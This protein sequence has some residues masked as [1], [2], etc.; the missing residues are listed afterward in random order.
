MKNP[1]SRFALSLIVVVLQSA[2]FVW[3]QS[4]QSET[5]PPAAQAALDK[6]LAAAKQEQWTIA[7]QSLDQARQLAPKTP[8]ILFNQALAESRVPGRELRSIVLFKA[9]LAA[10]PNATNAAAVK[11][12]ITNLQIKV[13]G[14][15]ESIFE[16]AR[17]IVPKLPNT[18][19]DRY[20]AW[21]DLIETKARLGDVN[22]ARQMTPACGDAFQYQ[23]EADLSSIQAEL[24][25]FSGAKSTLQDAVYDANASLNHRGDF[26]Q[27]DRNYVIG[28]ITSQVYA[29]IIRYEAEAGKVQDAV[30]D[31][32]HH[33]DLVKPNLN[34]PNTGLLLE[35]AK[36]QSQAGQQA[37]RLTL[38]R[39]FGNLKETEEK[40]PNSTG[41]YSVQV[42]AAQLD[43]NDPEGARQTLSLL[44]PQLRA[45]SES[46]DLD[47]AFLR[48]ALVEWKRGDLSS[49]KQDLSQ[50]GNGY[51][52][53]I[54][55]WKNVDW[56]AANVICCGPFNRD[57]LLRLL[58]A[59][60]D[61]SE[62]SLTPPSQPV[63]S[64]VD[65]WTDLLNDPLNGPLFT[66]LH[67][68]LQ[69]ISAAN[70]PQA[71]LQGLLGAAQQIY[72]ASTKIK[73]TA[74]DLAK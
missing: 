70:T 72:N 41:P 42:A 44:S 27:G 55:G 1:S 11:D 63:K 10:A 40:Y 50:L 7:I 16:Q 58:Q 73:Q 26:D 67:L 15:I 25:D 12:Q 36:A 8:V 34:S 20:W 17:D 49:A 13:D 57:D 69:I 32:A 62:L 19:N 65:I 6:G 30:D 3:A 61:A 29:S 68:Q 48:R 56:R 37:A 14:T 60:A 5:L 23:C 64:P 39:A 35:I 31:L 66:D 51:I 46:P 21:K 24:R 59:R 9:Y 71:I 18:P 4:Q 43:A 22:G 74:A 47:N 54:W 33:S 53:N 2:C 45:T 38:D 52:V 28:L